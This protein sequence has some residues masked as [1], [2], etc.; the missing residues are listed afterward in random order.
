[1][2]CRICGKTLIGQDDDICHVCKLGI[3]PEAIKL[4]EISNEKPNGTG[5][6]CAS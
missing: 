3:S 4:K 1:M 6:T 5:D 2:K